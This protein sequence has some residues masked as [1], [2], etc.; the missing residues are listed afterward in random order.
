VTLKQNI[1]GVIVAEII[2]ENMTELKKR[3]VMKKSDKCTIALA[4]IGIIVAAISLIYFSFPNNRKTTN[5]FAII[6]VNKVN[7][8]LSI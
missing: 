6:L 2:A 3:N 4:V 8:C 1:M 5:D 7:N